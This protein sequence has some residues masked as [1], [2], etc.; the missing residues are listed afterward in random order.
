LVLRPIAWN[1]RKVAEVTKYLHRPIE[2]TIEGQEVRFFCVGYIAA[3]LNRSRA[4]ICRWERLG[5]F[6]KAHYI[7]KPNDR[8]VRRRLYSEAFLDAL[9]ELV[10]SRPLEPRLERDQWAR[11]SHA[12][13]AAH[14]DAAPFSEVTGHSK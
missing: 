12:V 5:L 4:T 14:H 6:P 2:L 11:F 8:C 9:Q 3:I 7:L 10:V 1:D 13:F